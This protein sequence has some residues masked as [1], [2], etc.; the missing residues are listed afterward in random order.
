M[1]GPRLRRWAIALAAAVAVLAAVAT[2]G[3]ALLNLERYRAQIARQVGRAIGR[4]VTVGAIT[5]SLWRLGAEAQGIRVAD[6]A[7]YGTAPFL[8]AEALR[9]RVELLPLL[10]GSVRVASAVLERPRIHLA[11]DRAGR[12]NIEDLWAVFAGGPGAGPPGR[13]APEP[14]R[15]PRSPAAAGAL[16][17]AELRARGGEI[18]I[19]DARPGREG[20]ASFAIRNLRLD[21]R[22]ADARDPLAVELEGDVPG[23]TLRLTATVAAQG[24]PLAIDGRAVV[25]GLDLG[26]FGAYLP[27]DGLSGP[28]DAT[29]TAKGPAGALEVSGELD[30]ARARVNLGTF[31]RKGP[32]EEARLTFAGRTAGEGIDLPKVRL[33]W[34][35]TT[36]DGRASVARFHPLE[37]TFAAQA[38]QVDLDRLLAVPDGAGKDGGKE[39]SQ[40]RPSA[41]GQRDRGT[42]GKPLG[43]RKEAAR[44]GVWGGG[45]A[46]AAPAPDPAGTRPAAAKGPGVGAPVRAEGTVR[47]AAV[48][49]R[50]LEAR[51]ARA[52][53]IYRDAILDVRDVAGTLA[54]GRLAA[55]GTVDL[56]GQHPALAMAFKLDEA[57]LQPLVAA[58]GRQKVQAQGVVTADGKITSPALGLS[59]PLGSLAGTGSFV[60]RDG[61]VTGY[62]PLER[63][64]DAL[65]SITGGAKLFKAKLDEFQRLNAT[66]TLDKGFLRTRDLTLVRADG[67]A[68]AAGSL[69]LLDASLNFDVVL[70]VGKVT[71]EAK[72]LGT[73][74]EPMV[75]PT[76]ARLDR[77]FE[78]EIDRALKGNRGKKIQDLLRNLLR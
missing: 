66:L 6:R 54:G 51:D 1:G 2:F 73:T 16:L 59:N 64:E 34:K 11:R 70:R 52:R 30:L 4:D 71:V 56:R 29:L 61:R 13:P 68:T 76:V 10:R 39:D 62:T 12:W 45:V 41:E 43:G 55:S 21:L 37:V 5:A 22:Q 28:A 44:L 65:S 17:V 50:G 58:A 3:P 18:R 74:A 24:N 7:G 47:A 57:Q 31:A 49:W 40:G 48:R 25:K 35:G 75:V 63:I 27:R 78:M 53:L 42:E 32:G 23:G 15:P 8:E 9:V 69:N 14:R 38:E 33:Q 26:A 20:A 72:V 77:R 60:V 67:Q 19:D 36:A 46:W